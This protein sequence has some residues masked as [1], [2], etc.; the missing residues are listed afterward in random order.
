VVAI[1]S[2]NE[3]DSI[4]T[5]T[6]MADETLKRFFPDKKS[7]II[8][9]DNASP[10]QTR[11]VFLQVPT[12]TPK[13]HLSTPE[14]VTRK[15]NDLLNLFQRSLELGAKGLV[16]VDADVQSITP[17]WIRN[18]V[19]PLCNGYDFVATVYVKHR[20]EW[21]VSNSTIYPMIRCLYGR[22]VRKPMGRDSA[23]SERLAKMLIDEIWDENATGF[24]VNTWITT[25]AVTSGLPICQS[26]L[27]GPRIHKAKD[28]PSH[29]MPAVSSD[30][31]RVLFSLWRRTRI[32]GG[33]CDGASPFR[34]L[35]SM[36][37]RFRNHKRC[38]CPS[39]IH[40]SN[41]KRGSFASKTYG[42]KYSTR[43]CL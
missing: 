38:S 17:E 30:N 34:S 11:D 37:T 8:N 5:P 31:C 18:L 28:P 39:S 13:I 42:G 35:V 21:T 27:G 7:M 3:A 33:R 9:C 12:E 36:K 43:M 10:D 4:Q 24:G 41:S 23:I 6:A 16:V 20:H 2:L 14:G 19:E 25:L 1:P 22:R 29:L 32:I 15:G 40:S 26:F